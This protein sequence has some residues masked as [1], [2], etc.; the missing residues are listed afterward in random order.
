MRKPLFMGSN[1]L[2]Q[3]ELISKVW[4]LYMSPQKSPFSQVCGTPGPENWQGVD[5]LSLFKTLRPKISYPRKL[6]E[7][8]LA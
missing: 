5:Q 2:M 3:L 8:Y 6:K 4:H 1:E 7:D